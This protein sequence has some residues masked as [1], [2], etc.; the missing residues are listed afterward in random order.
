MLRDGDIVGTDDA[1]RTALLLMLDPW[2][3]G[4]LLAFDADAADL[5]DGDGE[6]EPYEERDGAATVLDFV[7]PK[8]LSLASPVAQV[9]ALALLLVTAPLV[10]SHADQGPVITPLPM[11]TA[12]APAHCCRICRKGQPCGD[13]C[14]SATKQCRKDQ[15]CA[16]SA[17]GG[18]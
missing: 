2:T 6:P 1:G 17:A 14:I 9:V 18:S 13:G 4:R 3:L 16:C 10:K 5:E 8:W 11:L 12:Q 7:P 15:G